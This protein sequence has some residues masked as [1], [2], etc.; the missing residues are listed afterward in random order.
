MNVMA[1]MD[2]D[3]VD[4]IVTDP[5]YGIGFM[6]HEWDQPGKHGPL[7]AAGAT[8]DFASGRKYPGKHVVAGA[9]R[10]SQPSPLSG[11]GHARERVP[12]RKNHYVDGGP[13]EGVRFGGPTGIDN[14]TH[15]LRGGAM[16]AGR[17]D[18]SP[19]ANERFEDWCREWASRALRVLKPGGFL[20]VFGGTRTY[21]RLACGVE[22]AGF[23]IR[24]QLVWLFG[25]GFPKSRN[26]LHG[27]LTLS[28]S[29][30]RVAWREWHRLARVMSGTALKPGYEPILMARKPL[31]GTVA[32]NLLEWK[33]GALNIKG[34]GVEL[35]D[36]AAY[37]QNCSGP[38]GH[39]GTRTL[40]QRGATDLRMG[41][42]TPREARWPPNVLLDEDAAAMLDAQSGQLTSGS[43][44]LRRNADKFG[45]NTYGTFK[46]TD[47]VL[48]PG[49]SGGASRFFYCAKT[50]R[51]ERNAG[52]KGFEEK[53]LL[54]SSGEQNPGAF[55]SEGTNRAA[56]NSHPTVKPIT[57]MRWLIR[58]V[59]PPNGLVLD[60][61]TGSGSTG[62]AAAL[63]DV[64]FLGIERHVEY[65]QIARARIAWWAAHPEGL[66]FDKALTS[67]SRQRA[68]RARGEMS[69]FDA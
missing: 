9:K 27:M 69:L 21:H 54:W 55:Q 66:E 20:L 24:D 13:R 36:K 61:F 18:L 46:G 26:P 3:S 35:Q 29:T 49:D 6:G 59:T 62:A 45:R 44:P 48:P 11:A 47:E 40:K 10:R 67:E 19:V 34:C 17:Y 53:P 51:A 42:G 60:P 30:T 2:V 33:V 43:G 64:R 12:Q 52:L 8:T 4:V 5:P 14:T 23:E 1:E 65:V 31:D 56:V 57:V 7:A 39:A 16:H 25:S 22:D 32:S 63:E 58:L 50:S 38:R 28:R 15:T 41:G 37:E 68:M